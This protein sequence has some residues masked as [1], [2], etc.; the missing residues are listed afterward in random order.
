VVNDASRFKF[1]SMNNV[2][3]PADLK[4]GE[5]VDI[6]NWDCDNDGGISTRSPFITGLVQQPVQDNYR[7]GGRS[8]F[9]V[10]NTVLCTVALS[11]SVDERFATVISLDDM[12][13][14]IV[15]VDEGLFVGSTKELHFLSG[16]DPQQGGFH[17][18]WAL[19]WGVITGTGLP[20][21][22]EKV[23]IAE[24][25]GNCAIFATTQGVVVG[26][27]G[28]RIKNLSENRVSYPYGITGKAM[29]REQGGLVHYLF[30]TALS[31]SAF[32]PFEPLI[33]GEA[34]E[35]ISIQ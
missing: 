4:A 20:I 9:A 6:C 23:P 12:I 25:S 21:K 29:I 19:P 30:T 7:L 16:T 3:D 17:D 27:P 11:A 1:F 18:V 10:G 8:Y 15:R 24:M 31:Q 22:G 26:G 14:M 35:S 5:C 13:T 32:N 34:S 2:I 33:L 28:G